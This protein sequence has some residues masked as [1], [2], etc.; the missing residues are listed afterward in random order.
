MENKKFKQYYTRWL[1]KVHELLNSH[2]DLIASRVEECEI[3]FNGD[4]FSLNGEEI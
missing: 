2:I 1:L 3:D 4:R